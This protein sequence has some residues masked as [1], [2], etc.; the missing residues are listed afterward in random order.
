MGFWQKKKIGL[1]E[2]TKLYEQ[3]KGKFGHLDGKEKDFAKF[4]LDGM[5]AILGL[6]VTY[7]EE[8][9]K[10]VAELIVRKNA[11]EDATAALVSD[12]LANM[13]V[14]REQMV[15]EEEKGAVAAA[16]LGEKRSYVKAVLNYFV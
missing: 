9:D 16:A 14:L 10:L 7:K 11:V 1:K 6:P 8:G 3:A 12:L 5:A 4:M 2:V 13:A 15:D